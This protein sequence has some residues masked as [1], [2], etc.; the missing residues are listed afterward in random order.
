M[1][2]LQDKLQSILSDPDAMGRIMSIAQSLTGPQE[3]AA[4]AAQAPPPPAAP[5]GGGD[6]LSLL[7]NLDPRLVQ[8]GMRLLGEYNAQD[9]RKTALLNALRPFVRPERYAKVDQAIKIARLTRVIRAA[10]ETFRKGGT[11]DV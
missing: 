6:P 10:L 2:E 8:L 3:D 1:S 5:E 7:G 11:E 9:D 4:P